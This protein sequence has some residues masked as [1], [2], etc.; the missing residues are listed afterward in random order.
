MTGVEIPRPIGHVVSIHGEPLT[1]YP[2]PFGPG[3][4]AFRNE[5]GAGPYTKMAGCPNCGKH[6]G[7]WWDSIDYA[8]HM[9]SGYDPNQVCSRVCEYQLEWAA[10]LASRK[11]TA[12]NS[13]SVDP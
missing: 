6:A 12:P 10:E 8:G 4:V 1:V 3:E 9:N 5:D 11:L 2:S 13:E 7:E